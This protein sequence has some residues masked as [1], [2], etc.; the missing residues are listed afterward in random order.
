MP[1]IYIL[2]HGE[3]VW[4][5][6]SRFQ[7]ALD[8]PLTAKGEAQARIQGRIVSRILAETPNLS[9]YCSP[10]GR[11]RATWEIARG[12]YDGPVAFDERLAEVNMGAWQGLTRDE[13]ATRWPT[14]FSNPGSYLERALTAPEGERYASLLTRVLGVLDDLNG[15]TLIV[16]HGVTSSVIR[17][18]CLGLEFDEMTWLD[19]EQGVVFAIRD[20]VET[21]LR[22]A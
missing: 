19:H 22:E 10:Q 8:S 12:G 2:R 21:V 7:G 17:G 1:P 16:T 18:L 11:A 4:N 5:L 13:A 14:L 15:P 20:G 3:T 9:V 6:E